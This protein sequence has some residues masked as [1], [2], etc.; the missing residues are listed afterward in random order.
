MKVKE[1]MTTQ[2]ITVREDQTK[3]QVAQLLTQHRIS[4]VPVVRNGNVAVGIVTEYDIIAKEGQ[5]VSD[6]MTLGLISV[7]ED[8]ELEE[9]SRILIHE[10]IKRVLV[11]D[12]GH[13]VGIVGRADLIKEV[14]MRWV[15]PVCGEMVHSQIPPQVCPRC[16]TTK[17]AALAESVS[18]G[19]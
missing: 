15:C 6:I 7:S 5:R 17:I 10:R 3:K 14:A 1:V 8:T 4:G 19:F 13:L 9:V 16:G 12:H 18:P 2:V 11:L